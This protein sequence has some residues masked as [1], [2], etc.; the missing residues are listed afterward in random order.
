MCDGG[1]LSP[2][3]PLLS[4]L[5]A[6]PVVQCGPSV[7]PL[8]VCSYFVLYR[9]FLLSARARKTDGRRRRSSSD[10]PHCQASERASEQAVECVNLN[11]S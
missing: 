10:C 11:R 8:S 1:G 6:V 9:T 3:S 4:P 7:R 5:C 2:P